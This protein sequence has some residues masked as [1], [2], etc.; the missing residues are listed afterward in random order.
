M[1]LVNFFQHIETVAKVQA[2]HRLRLDSCKAKK[3]QEG[4]VIWVCQKQ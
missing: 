3:K 1:Y 2:V 4:L